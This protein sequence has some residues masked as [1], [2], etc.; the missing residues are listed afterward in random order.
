ME[1]LVYFFASSA[2]IIIAITVPLFIIIIGVLTLLAINH[3]H[4]LPKMQQSVENIEKYLLFLVKL[5][6]KKYGADIDESP[7]EQ[8]PES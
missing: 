6:K 4:R 3:L 5:E 8:P 7:A 2:G 1:N